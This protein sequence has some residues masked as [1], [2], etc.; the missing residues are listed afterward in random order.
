M[1]E[2][3]KTNDLSGSYSMHD[4]LFEM[5][6]SYAILNDDTYPGADHR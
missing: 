6:E 3:I 4:N 1:I 2:N 5:Y